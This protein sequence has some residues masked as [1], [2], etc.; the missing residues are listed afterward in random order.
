MAG[1]AAQVRV[2][3]TTYLP[4]ALVIAAKNGQLNEIAY[5]VPFISVPSVFETRRPW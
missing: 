1:R 3:D 4:Q 2:C 5:L